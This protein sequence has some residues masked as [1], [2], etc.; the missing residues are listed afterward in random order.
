MKKTGSQMIVECLKKEGVETLFNYP[1]GAVLPLFDELVSAPFHQ[2]L[3]RHE[4]AAV[5]A[6]DGYARASGKVGVV[7]VTSGPGATN[8]VTG[9]ATAYMDSIPI[10]ILTGQIPTSLIGNDAFQEADIVG[11]TRPCTKHN[12]LVKEIKDLNQIIKEAFYIARSGRPG[13]VLVDLPKDILIDSAEFKYPEKVFIRGYRPTLEGHP[14]Q[15]QRAIHLILKS[16]RPLL[17]VGGGIISSNASKELFH[18]AEKLSL[19]VTMTLMGLGGFPG[20]HSLS[21]GMLGMHGTY[22]AN[23]AVMES[24]LLIAVGARFDDRVTGKLESFAPQARVIHIDIDPT[25]ISKNV[26]VD[27]PIVG[28]CKHILSK[29]ISLIEKEDAHS[30]KEGLQKW[31]RQIENWKAIYDM[32]YQQ[33]HLI[34]PQYVI[35]KVDELTGGEA[36]V[37]T[38]VGQNQMWAAQYYKYRKPRTLLTSGGLGTMG[39]GLPAAIGAQVAFP[40]RMVIGISG[41]GSFQMNSQ[42]LATVVQYRLPIKVVIL[43]NGYLGMVRQW[44]EFFYGKRYASSSLEGVSPDF[45][46]LAEAYGA[47]GLRA[48]KPEEVV[49]VLKK[50]FS[51]PEPVVIDFVIDPEEN[52]YP[53]VPAGEPLNQM[54]L[55]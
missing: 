30:F 7:V 44:Q 41:D 21:L 6:A 10:V 37:T 50:A 29:I 52:V 48:N 38:E 28:D 18:L 5:H 26:R 31:H 55:V 42:E 34:K 9:I 19:P 53:M 39:Y 32:N 24:D 14:G 23:M 45:V 12:Y 15:I 47:V 22:Q 54:R 13:P 20:N 33:E 49:P 4:Q 27:L 43:N 2:I 36:I 17:Y 8:T 1:G 16:K 3:V 46:K 11:I 25:S 51:I 40:N 35:E